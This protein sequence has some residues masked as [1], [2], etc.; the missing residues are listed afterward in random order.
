MVTE[1]ELVQGCKKE[2]SHYQRMLYDKYAGKLMAVS[3]RYSNSLPDAED[4]LQEAFITIFNKIGQFK[5]EGSLE[6]WLRRIV[7]NTAIRKLQKQKKMKLS[8][9]NDATLEAKEVSI[10]SKLSE[11]ELLNLIRKLPDGYRNV[12]NMFAIEGYSHKEIAEE[13]SISEGTSRSQYLRARSFL[14]DLISKIK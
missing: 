9:L 8:E 12:F 14:R 1:K 3:L 10:L 11:K 7:V 2:K 4:N 6:G 5:G 13:L